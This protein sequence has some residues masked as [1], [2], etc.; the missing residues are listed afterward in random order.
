[1]LALI[2]VFNKQNVGQGIKV[3]KKTFSTKAI[4]QESPKNSFDKLDSARNFEKHGELS[5]P[6]KRF[7]PR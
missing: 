3:K 1:M 7:L 2:K 5:S 4:Q 6:A